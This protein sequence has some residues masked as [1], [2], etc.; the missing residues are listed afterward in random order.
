MPA[1]AGS[2]IPPQAPGNIVIFIK[3]S[4]DISYDLLESQAGNS[5]YPIKEGEHHLVHTLLLPFHL[6]Q[7]PLIG[8]IQ[9]EARRQ[10][11]SLLPIQVSLPGTEQPGK[12][13]GVDIKEE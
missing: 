5:Q 4:P 2:S 12:G 7:M 8:H 10:R 11:G 6:L 1:I 3:R 13:W 9:E